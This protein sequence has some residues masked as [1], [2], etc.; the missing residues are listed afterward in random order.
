MLVNDQ[1][2]YKTLAEFV[3]AAKKEP[4]KIVYSSGGLYGASHLP[5]ALLEQAAGLEGHASSADRRRRAG[6]HGGARQ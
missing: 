1:Q 3:D 5:V 6:D 4:Q 2:P